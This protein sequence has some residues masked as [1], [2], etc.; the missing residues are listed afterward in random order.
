MQFI[1]TY[2]DIFDKEYCDRVIDSFDVC[3]RVGAITK[4]R[5]INGPID[6][7]V[8]LNPGIDNYERVNEIDLREETIAHRFFDGISLGIERYF[9][10]LSIP[11]QEYFLRNMV[12]QRSDPVDSGGYHT[13]HYEA[14]DRGTCER[15]M[16]YIL[17]LNDIP[18]GEGETEF[19][20]QHHRQQPRAGDL[21]IWPAGYTHIHRGNSVRTTVKYIATGW[22]YW[23]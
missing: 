16:V 14:W 4:R 22:V 13:W 2:N 3:S 1:K 12:V 5:N 10:D 8:E 15:R 17:Y 11:N 20:Y 6:E 21:V 9:M 18:E 23:G 7:R 19:L